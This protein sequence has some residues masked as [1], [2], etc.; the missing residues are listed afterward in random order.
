MAYAGES[1]VGASEA[2]Q[3]TVALLIA[4][5]LASGLSVSVC[6]GA[7]LFW[8]RAAAARR[9]RRAET[10]LRAEIARGL[11]EI[12]RFAAVQAENACPK[13]PPDAPGGTDTG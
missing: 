12:E 8:L 3:F 6:Y 9:R 2:M 7:R 1:V 5:L 13:D 4:A 11:A 10:A